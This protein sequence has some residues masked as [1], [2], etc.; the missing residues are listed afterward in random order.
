MINDKVR[1]KLIEFWFQVK[2]MNGDSYQGRHDS[3]KTQLET[4]CDWYEVMSGDAF[5]SRLVRAS[6]RIT[7]GHFNMNCLQQTCMMEKVAR[8]WGSKNRDIVVEGEASRSLALELPTFS[9]RFFVNHLTIAHGI[10]K[11]SS[12]SVD[13]TWYLIQRTQR[14]TY[15]A[16][17]W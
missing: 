12:Q 2:I 6:W 17:G 3:Y 11:T 16:R 10:G 8:R 5:E 9:G 7:M 15:S 13:E 1:Q 4:E 14:D